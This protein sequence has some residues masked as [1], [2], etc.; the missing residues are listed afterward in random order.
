MQLCMILWATTSRS[1]IS[2]GIVTYLLYFKK[3]LSSER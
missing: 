1:A 2:T 3:L